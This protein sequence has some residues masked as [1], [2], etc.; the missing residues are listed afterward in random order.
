[1][2][3]RRV[4]SCLA[5][6]VGALVLGTPHAAMAAKRPRPDL[7]VNRVAPAPSV[8]PGALLQ[9][10]VKVHNI[11][12]ARAR[13]SATGMFL[14]RDGRWDRED[15][16]LAPRP[17]VPALARRKTDTREVAL[18]VPADVE[19]GRYSVIG[20]ADVKRRVRER[21]ESNNCRVGAPALEVV[22]IG[23]GFVPPIPSPTAVPTVTASPTPT[24]GMTP[25]PTAVTPTPEPTPTA[26]PEPTPSPTATSTGSPTPSAT[27]SPS[28]TPTLSPSPTPSPTATPTVPPPEPLEGEQTLFVDAPALDESRP[29]SM[30]DTARFL[31]SGPDAPQ[32]GVSAGT[33]ARDRVAIVRGRVLGADGQPLEGVRVDVL[34]HA[35]YGH[36]RTRP[37]GGWD[38]AVNGGGV[39]TVTMARA[40]YLP[41]QRD[42]SLTWLDWQ[43]VDDVVLVPLDAATTEVT[44]A[45]PGM[46]VARGS[47]VTD[48]DGTRRATLLIPHGVTAGLRMPGAPDQPAPTLTLRATEYTVGALGE[49]RMP[50]ELPPSSAYTYA[51][52]WSADEAGAA[53]ATGVTFSS[54]VMAYAE[55][56]RDFDVG[57]AIPVGSYDH[58]TGEWKA[59]DDGR[60]IAITAE[61]VGRAEVD[62]DG[63]GIADTGAALTALGFTDAE[64]EKLALLYDPGAELM[65]T[66]TRHFSPGDWNWPLIPED[67]GEPE[68]PDPPPPH[69]RDPEDDK[70]DGDDC[71]T[72]SIIYC[73]QRAV[74]EMLDVPGT[75]ADLFYTSGS[76]WRP[77][78]KVVNVP[79][80]GEHVSSRLFRVRFVLRFAGRYVAKEVGNAPNMVH[81]F[82]WDG[83]D[84]YGRRLSGPVPLE[85]SI[86]YVYRNPLRPFYGPS[87]ARSGPVWAGWSD[88]TGTL[89][90]GVQPTY[91]EV[92]RCTSSR[93]TIEAPGRPSVRG[94]GLGGWNVAV[95]HEYDPT[96]RVLYLGT[97]EQV[98]RDPTLTGVRSERPILPGTI[99]RFHDVVYRPDGAAYMIAEAQDGGAMWIVRADP[100][101]T[102]T[103]I[104]PRTGPD[105]LIEPQ[106]LALMPDGDLLV[107]D[108]STYQI[109]RITPGGARSVF[110]GTGVFGSGPDGGQAAQTAL[111]P[112]D[113]AVDRDGAVW[114]IDRGN[115]DLVRRIDPSGTVAT[116]A[117]AGTQRPLAALASGTHLDRPIGIVAAPDGSIYVALYDEGLHRIDKTGVMRRVALPPEIQPRMLDVDPQGNVLFSW[118]EDI[119]SPHGSEGTPRAQV[120][121]LSRDGTIERVCRDGG[122]QGTPGSSR[123]GGLLISRGDCGG[124]FNQVA[125]VAF[126]PDGTMMMTVGDKLVAADRALPPPPPPQPPAVPGFA[127]GELLVPSTDGSELYVFSPAGK[128]LRTLDALTGAVLWRFQYRQHLGQPGELLRV[129]D[130]EERAM[131]LPAEP[132]SGAHQITSPDGQVTE[133]DIVYDAFAAQDVLTRFDPP[134]PASYTMTYESGQTLSSITGPHGTQEFDYDDEGRLVSDRGP[135]G[136]LTTLAFDDAADGSRTQTTVTRAGE[137]TVYVSEKLPSG[138]IRRTV[139]GP[140]GATTV[141]VQR[142]SGTTR[143]TRP[144]GVTIDT[145]IG[146]DPR[147]GMLA[148]VTEQVRWTYPSGRTL[149]QKLRREVTGL[150]GNGNP[151]DFEKLRTE[152]EVNGDTHATTFDRSEFTIAST[153]PAGRTARYELDGK[154]R[155][156]TAQLDPALAATTYAY[157]GAGRLTATGYA[158]GA[159]TG[160]A[161]QQWTYSYDG[162]GR[163]ATRTTAGG[164]VTAMAYDAGDRLTL[165]D[166]PGAGTVAF[167]RNQA[168]DVTSVTDE[169][170]RTHALGRDV[171][172]R[173]TSY[174]PP[175]GAASTRTYNAQGRLASR[176]PAGRAPITH[177]YD[178]GGRPTAISSAEATTTIAYPEGDGTRRPATVTRTPAG[179]GTPAQI[180]YGYDGDTVTGLAMTG[181]ATGSFT[182]AYD[183]DGRITSR[184][185]QAGATVNDV[186]GYDADGYPVSDGFA[187]IA[188][189]GPGGSASGYA[190]GAY[191]LS[192]AYDKAGRVRSRTTNVDGH[193][194]YAYALRHDADGR[195]RRREETVGGQTVA[196]EYDYDPRGRLTEVRRDGQVVEAYEYDAAG[197]RVSAQSGGP[198]RAATYD[199]QGRLTALGTTQYSFDAAGFLAAR[200][201]D[202]F[203]YGAQ[204]ELL[205]ATVDGQ[206]VTYAYDAFNRRI[207]RTAGGQSWQYL[208]GDLRD[209]F[210]VSAVREPGGALTVLRYDDEGLLI[211]FERA[212]SR[213]HVATDQVG[214]PRVVTD[215][216]GAVVRTIAYDSFGRVTASTGTAEVPLGF[217]GGLADELTGLVRFGMRDYDPAAGRWTARDP[218][219][220]EAGQSNLYLYVAGDPVGS[221]D[222]SGLIAV[223]GGISAYAGLGAGF[224]ICL[225][226]EGI[227]TCVE[228]GFGI[229]GS[230]NAGPAS[231]IEDPSDAKA[232]G[233]VGVAIGP[234]GIGAEVEPFPPDTP[235]PQ[236]F[237]GK[238][239][240]QL[241][242]VA[243]E[244]DKVQLSQDTVDAAETKLRGLKLGLSAKLVAKKCWSTKGI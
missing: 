179:S 74:G 219:L 210:R 55:N 242:P 121:R 104:T 75:E 76:A 18:R 188:R 194:R 70:R 57:A 111:Y 72:G 199:A 229:G 164:A 233:E 40:G 201:S 124:G 150:A 166:P 244:A 24:A 118:V 156:V 79:L 61:T 125:P 128:H 222:P 232:L 22:P 162:A 82:R 141:Q 101:G 9:A 102:T 1:M 206:T 100:D 14:S 135:D 28:G 173:Q 182:Y 144:D 112:E 190:A 126:R 63:D 30:E 117:G 231:D 69:P 177:S 35:E 60:V 83:R 36:T 119:P 49:A 159:Q 12:R 160:D 44:F 196:T 120:S 94:S 26:T 96:R 134:G 197:N 105:A 241:G 21:S 149:V 202:T 106:R 6:F 240:G 138:D 145:V 228:A 115:D 87:P 133:I 200:G 97:G 113:L 189:S 195:V 165:L 88:G 43:V 73:Q 198:A 174:T 154:G 66:P 237:R 234:M 32:Q 158:E 95:H 239:K 52:D 2:C 78:T 3:R 204:G 148:P 235:C 169:S 180:A 31:Y 116:V 67:L 42:V 151:L 213:F 193:Q 53:G 221:R 207:A 214:S 208:Y 123:L 4:C 90:G 212:G 64:L 225:G 243:L 191:A 227:S 172:G 187:T 122:P 103:D 218:V 10:R 152:V 238:L 68:Y 139:T 80:T 163:P 93:S 98:S 39:L 107:A 38:L 184:S 146:P 41:S 129:I 181:P 33:I 89:G 19:L 185:L 99:R 137:P 29:I 11:G 136:V 62:V 175:E 127:A 20:C 217:A 110:A 130:R 109:Y 153:S 226:D 17:R 192:L 176:T 224:D 183:S 77:K 140:S 15:L 23:G 58:L 215:A 209:A 114:V 92:T 131:E 168:G 51:F 56:F 203:T 171:R 45:E 147:F 223:C 71:K 47:T 81:S 143:I 65:R 37:D 220:F 157:D 170:Q 132:D 7:V 155:T 108:H 236:W 142:P 34:G 84:A 186:L 54:A 216:A 230:T 16:A 46:K 5:T 25:T 178:A 50:G 161:P 27:A 167:G 86:C 48:E 85:A 13:G 8:A 205:A 91:V 59:E 211:G